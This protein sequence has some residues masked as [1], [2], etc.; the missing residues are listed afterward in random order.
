ME[1]DLICRVENVLP[2]TCVGVIHQ[3]PTFNEDAEC[4]GTVERREYG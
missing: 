2:G 3:S 1:V 4:S